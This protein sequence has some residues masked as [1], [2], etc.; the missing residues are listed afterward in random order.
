MK[1]HRSIESR[2]VKSRELG[3]SVHGSR[4][5]GSRTS[6][7][8]ALP[9]GTFALA[10]LGLLA[11]VATLEGCGGGGVNATA[12]S[13]AASV[14]E[15]GSPDASDGA[16][17]GGNGDAFVGA[18]DADATPLDG[19][20][21]D[22]ATDGGAPARLSVSGPD[23]LGPDGSK[24]ILR[25]WNWGEWGTEQPSDASDNAMQGATIVRIPLR[26]WGPYPTGVD[27]R[28]DSDPGH[29]EAGHLA[30]LDKTIGD[31]I[32]AGLWVDLF[33]DSNCGQGSP[34]L[35]TI[36]NCGTGSD[37]T[38]ANFENDAAS[39]KAFTEMWT[40]LAGHY[41]TWPKIAM[42]EILPEPN[43]GCSAGGGCSNWV[44]FAEFYAN[45]I[46]ALRV[47]DPVTPI[48][49]GPGGGYDIQKIDTAL[50]TGFPNLIYTG[51]LLSHAASLSTSIPA[52]TAFRSKNNVPVFIQQVGVKKSDANAEAT[53]NSVLG[54]LRDAG[55]GWTW[56]TYREPRAATGDG[57]APW[58]SAD[59][60][61]TWME[62][63]HWLGL[64]DGYFK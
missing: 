44:G 54:G 20:R 3:A 57:F 31:A 27:A 50:V 51:D 9:R 21:S 2:A 4:A 64:I 7:A 25:G 12:T 1:T 29:I 22:G 47:A 49:I 30:A 63:T 18:T 61:K 58:Y 34:S 11:P 8:R 14:V 35:D 60:G 6:T 17:S 23:I 28:L 43:W 33:V 26:W 55:I 42:Y 5:G 39:L 46:P 15:G 24:V 10:V 59:G 16:T 19:A 52:A 38:A 48:L 45:E 62:D 56:W 32:A 13:D 36:A 37:G 40:F 53:L 41:A